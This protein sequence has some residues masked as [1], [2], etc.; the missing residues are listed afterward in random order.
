MLALFLEYAD[1][2]EIRDVLDWTPL[3]TAVNCNSQENVKMLLNRGAKIDC[4]SVQGV[5]L[6]A[7][8]MN[9]KNIGK[10]IIFSM[11]IL[12][13]IIRTRSNSYGSRGTSDNSIE[14]TT[15]E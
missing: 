4:D 15:Y 1:D 2:L 13:V 10:N 7:T 14:F 8:A 11:L 6:I 5:D 3:S 12:I 9:S